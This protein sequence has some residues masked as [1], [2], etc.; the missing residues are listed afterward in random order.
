VR[1][2]HLNKVTF[3][4]KSGCKA[5]FDSASSVRESAVDH[6]SKKSLLSKR[7]ATHAIDDEEYIKSDSVQDESAAVDNETISE[8][9]YDNIVPDHSSPPPFKAPFNK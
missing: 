5:I 8:T 3:I 6:H 1:Y 7:R 4:C 9:S 2:D